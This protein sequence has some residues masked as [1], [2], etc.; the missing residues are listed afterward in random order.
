MA[1]RPRLPGALGV[2]AST[3]GLFFAGFSTHDYAEHLDR[4]L[5]GTHCSFIPGLVDVDKTEN[6]CKI[7][8]YSP[9]SALFRDRIWGGVPISLFGLGV[10]GLFFAMSLYVLLGGDRASKRSWQA[11]GVAA[12]TPLVFSCILFFISLTRLGHFCKLCVGL[13]VAS[14]ILAAS[15]ILALLKAGGSPSGAASTPGALSGDT[16]QTVRDPNLPWGLRAKKGDTVADDGAAPAKQNS[17]APAK[18]LVTEIPRGSV[19]VFPLVLAG[20]ALF[21][22]LPATVY[23]AALPS[24]KQY[25]RSCGTIIELTEK[26]G[27]LVKIPTT[28]PKQAALTFEDPLCPTC[29]AFHERLVDEGLYDKLD[30]TVAIFPL[31]SEC[32]WMLDKA[33]HPGACVLAKAFLCGDKTHES[34]AVLEWSYENQDELRDAGK[35]GVDQIRA[36]VKARFPNLDACIDSK[37]TKQRLDHVLQFAVA[38]KVRVS[39]PQL[40]L[41]ETRVCDED[42]DL[43]LRYTFAELAPQVTP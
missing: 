1:T 29:K 43:G 37:E 18:P 5:H 40:F 26:H 28:S 19:L 36:K 20:L 34:R 42:T 33:L 7:A 22:G 16:S 25:L 32:N 2:A 24:Y 39:T 9:Y 12:L 21:A 31:D 8:M 13:Y 6:A 17:P 41:G 30:L 35:A 4:Q 11:F 10:Y 14:A 38:N 15:G 3:L 23:A 27:A